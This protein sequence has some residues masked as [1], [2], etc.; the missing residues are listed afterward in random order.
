MLSAP[1][2]AIRSTYP[3]EIAGVVRAADV[4]S[5]KQVTRTPTA[6]AAAAR[7]RRTR[8]MVRPG[9]NRAGIRRSTST[10]TTRVMVSTR[11]C[12]SAR[13]GAPRTTNT[14]ATA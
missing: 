1:A 6:P 10:T 2:S 11:N 14:P 7:T 8:V 13:S 9:L 4:T 12:V 5:A 3:S